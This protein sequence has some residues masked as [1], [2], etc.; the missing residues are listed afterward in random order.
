L[1]SEAR[2]VKRYLFS[3]IASAEKPTIHR[4]SQTVDSKCAQLDSET[5]GG[6]QWT[7]LYEKVEFNMCS[8][9][10]FCR[11][12]RGQ[13]LVPILSSLLMIQQ[14][15]LLRS[16]L[17]QSQPRRQSVRC[18]FKN[19]D[20]VHCN[21]MTDMTTDM[22]FISTDTITMTPTLDLQLSSSPVVFER[23]QGC[24][25]D[26]TATG[27]G[28][29]LE[30]LHI[31]KTGGTA[32]EFAASTANISWGACKFYGKAFG[33]PCGPELLRR[34]AGNS[35]PTF[36]TLHQIN[37]FSSWHLPAHYYQFEA[38]NP[39][40]NAAVFA[41]VRNPYE[42]VI[43]EYFYIHELFQHENADDLNNA[44][45]MSNWISK[46]LSR[47]HS[48]TVHDELPL[49]IV[50]SENRRVPSHDYFQNDGHFIPQ[51]DYVYDGEHRRV[52]DHVLHFEHLDVEFEQLMKAYN[53]SSVVHLSSLNLG[54]LEQQGGCVTESVVPKSKLKKLGQYNLTHDTLRLIELV[55]ARDFRT[56]GYQKIS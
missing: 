56:F 41:V 39:Y 24:V 9:K 46:K 12:S 44:T 1:E 22:P 14:C 30:F 8:F 2:K 54:E 31:P 37:M 33:Q 36:M 29:R 5:T 17:N 25:D 3:Q 43:S 51:Y 55:Y 52:V 35:K 34:P 18:S 48:N 27:G 16:Y 32:V 53:L 42:R 15:Q 19:G 26:G 49:L 38:D 6:K 50:P 4:K 10:C 20:D 47:M 11:I 13:L 7:S 28:C 40:R 23:K 45:K 21:D